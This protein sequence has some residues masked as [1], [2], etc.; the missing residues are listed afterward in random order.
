MVHFETAKK[1]VT[2]LQLIVFLLGILQD[3]QALLFFPLQV[4]P[5]S[6]KKSTAY[7]IQALL[8]TGSVPTFRSI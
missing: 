6:L 7:N 2:S 5:A 8:T 4:Q 3:W 1:C